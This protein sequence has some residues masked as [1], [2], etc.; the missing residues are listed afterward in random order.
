MHLYL[1]RKWK[2]IQ[3]APSQHIDTGHWIDVSCFLELKLLFQLSNQAHKMLLPTIV[4]CKVGSMVG[5][6]LQDWSYIKTA[7]SKCN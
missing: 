4:K 2:H 1:F 3:K 7:L 6:H 5:I